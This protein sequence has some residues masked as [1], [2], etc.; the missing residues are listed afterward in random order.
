MSEPTLRSLKAIS[1]AINHAGG[2]KNIKVD[3]QM[4]IAVSGARQNQH[5]YLDEKKRNKEKK[6]KKRKTVMNAISEIQAKRK[7]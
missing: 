5:A 1:D 4:L 2:V 6:S 7:R 3:K